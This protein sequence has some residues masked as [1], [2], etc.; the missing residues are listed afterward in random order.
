LLEI[1]VEAL[2]VLLTHSVIPHELTERDL[3]SLLV[4][5][6]AFVNGLEKL[7][8]GMGTMTL[9]QVDV[10]RHVLSLMNTL[11]PSLRVLSI[12]EPTSQ[13]W[14]DVFDALKCARGSIKRAEELTRDLLVLED[15]SLNGGDLL[16]GVQRPGFDTVQADTYIKSFTDNIVNDVRRNWVFTESKISIQAPGKGR[17]TQST[18]SG[19]GVDRPVWDAKELVEDLY[20]HT[21]EWSAWYRRV[22]EASSLS[23]EY[24]VSVLF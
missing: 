6:T 9:Q 18:Q 23:T 2:R 17:N 8:Q 15:Y 13:A 10:L 16:A 22:F 21:K 24:C 14:D 4:T 11:W 12:C 19:Q 1:Y 5:V 3:P 7:N 20:E